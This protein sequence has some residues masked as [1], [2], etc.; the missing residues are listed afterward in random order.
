MVGS[1]LGFWLQEDMLG[2]LVSLVLVFG[3]LGGI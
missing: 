3:G 2:A 1:F